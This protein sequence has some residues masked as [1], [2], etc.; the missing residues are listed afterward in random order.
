M[1]PLRAGPFAFKGEEPLAFA[2]YTEFLEPLE[3]PIR[4]KRY[5]IP[6][7]SFEDGLRLAPLLEGKPV[8]GI[9][10]EEIEAL[11]L[12]SAAAE[13]RADGV[14]GDAINR[15]YLT[16]LAEYKFG[17]D[18]AE[19]MWATGG[20][21]KAIEARVKAATNRSQRRASKQSPSTGEATTTKRPGSTSTT[22]ASRKK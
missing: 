2:D 22:K 10:D 20:D 5:T 8:E 11:L 16:A 4:G 14:P 9:E 15:A 7:L 3:L 21:P 17:R 13:M 18:A 19:I 6:A 1:A 12:G